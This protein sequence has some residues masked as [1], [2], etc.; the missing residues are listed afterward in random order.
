MSGTAMILPLAWALSAAPSAAASP[1]SVE[2]TVR[3]RHEQV[4]DEAFAHDAHAETTRLRLAVRA[5]LGKGAFVLLEGEGI[6]SAGD[7]Y[8]SGANGRTAWPGIADPEGAELNQALVGWRGARFTTSLG[9]QRINWDNQRWIGSVGWRQNEQTFDAASLEFTASPKLTLRYA[10]LERVHRVSGDDAIDPLARERRLDSHLYNAGFKQGQQQW[11]AFAYLHHDRDVATSSSAT[12]GL[13]WTGTVRTRWGWT[14][15]VARQLDHANNPLGFGHS[16]WLVEPSLQARGVTWKLGWEH[17]G[18]DG[19]HALQTP[20][21]TLHAFNGWA[22]KFTS[23]PATG[24]DDAYVSATGKAGKLGW[25]VAA[26]DY[27]A[28]QGG[29]HFGREFNL[30]VGRALGTHWNGLV[31][32]ADYRADGFS[33]DT[34]KIWLQAEY[35]GKLPR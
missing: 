23:T 1:V 5:A 28:D 7:D 13:R 16:Y 14:A 18:G 6:A 29:Q 25:T 30:S 34:R 10:R 22:D 20:L 8:N 21:A 32:I 17:L 24:L 26:H 33:R 9:R 11:T 12:Y 2:W 31:K 4:R 27:R 35:T 3:F 19:R 15:E